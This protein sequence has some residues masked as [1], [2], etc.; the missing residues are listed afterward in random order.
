MSHEQP[1][2]ATRAVAV[3]F[4]GP[5]T[6]VLRGLRFGAGKHWAVLVHDVGKDLDGWRH[7][8]AWLG[9]RGLSVLAF[10]LPGHGASD[11][12]WEPQLAVA[13]VFAAVDF[14]R[15]NSS[16]QVHLVGDGVGALAALAVAAGGSHDIAS[17]TSVSPQADERVATLGDI[18]EARVP[19]LILVGSLSQSAV[20]FADHVF[21]GG[22]GPCEM[23][24]FPVARQGT[25]LLNGEW[26]SHAREKILAHLL[27]Q[28]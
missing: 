4:R 24:R 18:R 21:R 12:P 2:D 17:V 20:E 5:D 19:K 3:E 22:I 26:G 6:L 23:A 11:D 1:A 13:A 10:D 25:D 14:A 28:A 7:L 27:R 9:D 15:S 8:A 16:Q